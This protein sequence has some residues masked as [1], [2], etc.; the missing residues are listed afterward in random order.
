MCHD[1]GS[2]FPVAEGKSLRNETNERVWIAQGHQL[3]CYDYGGDKEGIDSLERW[4]QRSCDQDRK[5]EHAAHKEYGI[6]Y[7]IDAFS[8]KVGSIKAC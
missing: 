6:E 7:V 2:T 3:N 4:A 8:G 1:R 5:N